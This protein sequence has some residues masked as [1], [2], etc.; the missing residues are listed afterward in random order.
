M[1]LA[2][3]RM[4]SVAAHAAF[5][6]AA[7][8]LIA[9]LPASDARAQAANRSI[10]IVIPDEPPDLDPCNMDYSTIGRIVR[11]N[12]AE[13]LTEIDPTDGSITPRLATSWERVNDTTWRFK[14]RPGV[15]FS[16]GAAFDA[17]AAVASIERIMSKESVVAANGAKGGLE[18]SV[19]TRIFTDVQITAKAIDPATL[20]IVAS[21]AEPILPT[22]IGTVPMTSPNTPKDKL[23]K[24]PVGTGPY[25][26]DGWTAGQEIR[27]KRNPTYWGAQPQ[28]EAARY[29]WRNESSV[30]ASMVKIGEADFAPV[31]APQ[32]ANDPTMDVSYL[33]S[34]TTWIKIDVSQ[35]PLDDIRLRRA[36]N[37]AIDRDALR[38]TIF[39]KGVI[40]ATQV[41]V[42]S[43][44]GHN[45][46]LD[47]R[48]WPYDPAKAKAL[49]AEAKAAGTDVGK[50]LTIIGRTNHY[51]N[52]QEAM[53]A[54]MGMLQAVGLNIKLT[55]LEANEW[56]SV[57]RKPYKE[58]RG[59]IMVEAMHDN[60]MGD[61]VFS[62]F[63]RYAC[64][65]VT[66]TICNPELDKLIDKATE[67]SGPERLA[68]WKESFRIVYDDVVPD[69]NMF[70]MVGYSRVG[71]RIDFKP[72]IST[73]SE[74]QIAQM[75]FK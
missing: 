36:M 18:C 42:P 10:T 56:L 69:I 26:F 27:L 70:H 6:A 58:G 61:P 59:P 67:M 38:G 28:V 4:Y 23:T 54:M 74:I 35:P 17:A 57:N 41:V 64:K 60:N 53:E 9:A 63:S 24:A 1:R 75:K 43:I 51:P 47:K 7:F 34:E 22:R 32:D 68:A 52:V 20:E 15:K 12:V 46:D 21:K 50:E 44:A 66:S 29:V 71:K 8:G 72:S 55:M 37:Y 49:I 31:I 40:P 45:T 30:R 16:D 19:R 73:N 25:V 48:L 39:P 14:L 5:A 13:T 33:N 2:Q 3:H 62:V 65:G 11:Q